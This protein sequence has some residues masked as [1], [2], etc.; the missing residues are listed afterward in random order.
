MTAPGMKC[1]PQAQVDHPKRSTRRM[2][3]AADS[4]TTGSGVGTASAARAWITTRGL[5]PPHQPFVF[6]S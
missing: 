3:V 5:A 1:P 6:H 4:M 2:N